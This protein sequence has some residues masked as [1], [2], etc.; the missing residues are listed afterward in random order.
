MIAVNKNQYFQASWK[1]LRLLTRHIYC[2]KTPQHST[3]GQNFME[4]S[5][6]S[7]YKQKIFFLSYFITNNVFFLQFC[8]YSK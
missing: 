7:K 8:M 6:H 3:F 1:I 4:D 5:K 2:L